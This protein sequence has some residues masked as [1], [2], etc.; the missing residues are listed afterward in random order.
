MIDDDDTIPAAVV[1]GLLGPVFD[2]SDEQRAAAEPKPESNIVS[3][4]DYKQRL[5]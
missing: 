2:W 5:H 1:W 3:F 4:A